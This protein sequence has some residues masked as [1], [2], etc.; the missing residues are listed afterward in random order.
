MFLVLSIFPTEEEEA[1]SE[2]LVEAAGEAT[3]P[4]LGEAEV[5]LEEA[6]AKEGSTCSGKKNEYGSAS[7]GYAADESEAVEAI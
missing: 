5:E 3:M 6:E 2:E 7:E 1:E 4:E